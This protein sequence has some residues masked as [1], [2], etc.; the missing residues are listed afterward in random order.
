MNDIAMV[1]TIRL[2]SHNGEPAQKTDIVPKVT[3]VIEGKTT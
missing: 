1:T 3:A 2:A